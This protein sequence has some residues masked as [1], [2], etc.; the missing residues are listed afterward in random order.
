MSAVKILG[1][2][3]SVFVFLGV[4]INFLTTFYLNDNFIVLCMY[5]SLLVFFIVGII[6]VTISTS[7]LSKQYGYSAIFN[8]Y[9]TF[10]IIWIIAI[11]I[12]LI[13]PFLLTGLVGDAALW[14]LF[15]VGLIVRCMY[16]ASSEFLSRSFN[17]IS[18]YSKVGIFKISGNLYVAGTI[19]IVVLY[20]VASFLNAVYLPLIGAIF[21]LVASIL[22]F[23]AF[24]LLP[25]EGVKV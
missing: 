15:I 2:I 9:L 11:I 3:G 24:G 12:P 16:A 22:Q 1:V 4:L 19:L 5:I 20:I 8:H 23:V 17:A 25:K 21:L 18:S 13:S 10:G 6:L 7:L 14:A